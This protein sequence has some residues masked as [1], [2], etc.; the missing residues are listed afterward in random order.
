M[1]RT[2]QTE[3]GGAPNKNSMSKVAD[4]AESEGQEVLDVS[5]TVEGQDDVEDEVSVGE[6]DSSNGAEENERQRP[7]SLCFQ[8]S[9][10]VSGSRSSPFTGAS[11]KRELLREIIF[12][13]VVP[14][15][16]E[17]ELERIRNEISG[18]FV[19]IVFDGTSRVGEPA[20]RDALDHIQAHER[21]RDGTFDHTEFVVQQLKAKCTSVVCMKRDSCSTNGAACRRMKVMFT[22]S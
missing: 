5:C 10:S 6:A 17:D 3:D 21:A 18:Q 8:A 13:D 20:A 4:E 14:K 16:E 15:I 7:K 22:H 12:S 11:S 19:T 1:A 9:S 2:L